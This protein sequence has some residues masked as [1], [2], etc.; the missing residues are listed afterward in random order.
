MGKILETIRK[1][2]KRTLISAE[3]T[4]GKAAKH[5]SQE[6]LFPP[7]QRGEYYRNSFSRYVETV[8]QTAEAGAA[9]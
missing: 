5:R 9:T 4:S 8:G 2:R 6:S 3:I 7:L 1:E